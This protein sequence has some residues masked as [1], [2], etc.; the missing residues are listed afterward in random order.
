VIKPTAAFKP[1]GKKT[2]LTANFRWERK[3]LEQ[4]HK[5]ALDRIPI[6]ET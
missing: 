2:L 5:A 3:Q 4:Q 6:K 1:P